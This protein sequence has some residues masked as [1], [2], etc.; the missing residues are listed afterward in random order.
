MNESMWQGNISSNKPVVGRL[1]R[2]TVEEKE[3]D[4]ATSDEED[5][6]SVMEDYDMQESNEK[7]EGFSYFQF[8]ILHSSSTAF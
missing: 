3:D 7:C 2:L 1:G 6:V 8:W 4:S 5:F